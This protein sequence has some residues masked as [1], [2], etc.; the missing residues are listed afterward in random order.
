MRTVR[1]WLGGLRVRAARVGEFLGRPRVR[2]PAMLA[3]AALLVV[4]LLTAG[5]LGAVQYGVTF[6]RYRGFPAPSTPKTV[7]VAY[8]GG[9]RRVAVVPTTVDRILVRSPSLG[10]WEAPVYVVLPPGY[11]T[12]PWLHYPVLYLLHGSPGEPTNFFT[13]GD[14]LPTYEVLVAEK[15]VTPMLIVAPSGSR[16]FFSDT[17]WVNGTLPDSGWE[18]Y[19]SDT[20]VAAIDRRF[21]AIPDAAARGIGGLSEGGFGSL[22][23]AMHHPTE[24]SIIESWSGYEQAIDVPAVFDQDRALLAVNSPL[25]LLPH[26]ASVLKAHHVYVWMY[27]GSNDSLLS[28][29]TEFA[30]LLTSFGVPHHYAVLAGRHT[31]ALWRAMMAAALVVASEHLSHG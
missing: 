6:W 20:V 9:H 23:I 3:V 11:A 25:A 1:G 17:E 31:W 24:Y 13:V 18:T 30:S 22:N 14:L 21:R 4:G 12:H 5:T 26:R 15:R 16:G 2:R 10:D 7:L 27:V 19:V 28:Q 29:N 8:P